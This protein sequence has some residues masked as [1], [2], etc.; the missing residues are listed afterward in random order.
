MASTDL[1]TAPKRSEHND[2]GVVGPWSAHR[3]QL[4]ILGQQ[5]EIEHLTIEVNR[6]IEISNVHHDTLKVHRIL[7]VLDRAETPREPGNPN[8]FPPDSAW[9]AASRVNPSE[10]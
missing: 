7:P 3:R 6:S 8:T 5:L 9:P 10:G 1:A 2:L 4:I